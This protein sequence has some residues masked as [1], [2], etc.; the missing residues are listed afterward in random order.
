MKT[1][2]LVS[3]RKGSYPTL[4]GGEAKFLTDEFRKLASAISSIEQVM[5]KVEASGTV[6]SKDGAVTASDIPEGSYQV[7]HDTV[8]S[9][10]KLY[11]NVSGT[12]YSVALS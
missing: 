5:R 4:V 11:A 2:A 8:N 7:I 3:Y 1:D 12:L 9:T 6:A 10:V